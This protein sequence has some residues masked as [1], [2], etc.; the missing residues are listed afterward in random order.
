MPIWH[1]EK[2][3]S[4]YKP[5]R[6]GRVWGLVADA[7]KSNSRP[8]RG[9]LAN[10]VGVAAQTEKSR[11]CTQSAAGTRTS[12][13]SHKTRVESEVPGIEIRKFEYEYRD[14]EYEYKYEITCFRLGE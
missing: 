6:L 1:R 3:W 7:A 8:C 4:G 11:T 2:W 5:W 13:R 10:L 9:S 14:A 12:T